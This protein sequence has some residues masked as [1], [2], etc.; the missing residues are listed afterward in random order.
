MPACLNFF[1][2]RQYVL[3]LVLGLLTLLDPFGITSSSDAVSGKWLNRVFSHLYSTQGQQKIAVVIIDDAYL[4]SHDTFWP[5][6]YDEQSK[7]FKR[8]L[9]YRPRAV[10]VDLLYSH[11]HSTTDLAH[12][13]QLLANVFDRYQRQ[14][15]ALFLANTGR[16]AGDADEANAQGALTTVSSPALV[17]W[18]GLNGQ[19][20]L[21]QA[22]DLGPM[23][24]PALALYREY[25]KAYDCPEL[26]KDANAAVN[27]PAMALQWGSEPPD[28]QRKVAQVNNCDK[29]SVPW[30]QS[31]HEVWVGITS[32]QKG[33]DRGRCAPT[34]TLNAS[35]LEASDPQDRE[36][37]R[38]LLRGRLVLVGADVTSVNDLVTSPVHGKIPGVYLHA[39]ALDNLISKGMDYYHDAASVSLDGFD[40]SWVD[41]LELELLVLIAVLKK[42]TSRNEAKSLQGHSATL[43]LWATWFGFMALL[44]GITLML[45]LL[46]IT[47]ANVLGIATL[48]LALLGEKFNQYFSTPSAPR[49]IKGIQG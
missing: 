41:A 19:Y 11:D 49:P 37:I 3:G 45:Y 31:L 40:V 13:S 32:K 1:T 28:N 24:T 5:L 33:S 12:S 8:L 38:S 21:A 4:N 29:P 25:C 23:E 17:S 20:P 18:S 16:K 10:F 30:T 15:I 43:R 22:T 6:P 34:L 27:A 47:P 46:N 48:S 9:A 14:G 39:M 44:T 42:R 7:L 2:L 36:V 35:D 26:P